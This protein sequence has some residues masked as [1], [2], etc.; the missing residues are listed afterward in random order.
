MASKK[1]TS[2]RRLKSAKPSASALAKSTLPS[3]RL[4][5]SKPEAPVVLDFS[6]P[7]LVRAKL[8]GFDNVEEARAV[9]EIEDFSS[10]YWQID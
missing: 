10:S 5:L 3:G 6:D 4:K 8:R 2:E 7:A 1:K 9:L